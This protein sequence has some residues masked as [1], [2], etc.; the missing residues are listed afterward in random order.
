M[1]VASTQPRHLV[2]NADDL[3]QSPS[4]NAG[5]FDAIEFGIV[6]SASMMVRWDAA[7]DAAEWCRQRPEIGI[8]LHF[9]LGEW[10]FRDGSWHS[11]YEV[12]DA[13]DAVA[14][15][16]ELEWQLDRFEQLMDRAP[17]HLDSHQ[18]V[19]MREPARSAVLSVARSLGVPARGLGDIAYCGQFYGQ[20]GDGDRQPGNISYE[21]LLRLL[22]GIGRGT[23]ELACHPGADHIDDLKSMYLRERVTERDVLCDYRLREQLHARNIELCTFA[24]HR[25]VTV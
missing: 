17:T 14:V 9:D 23:T 12:V 8:G 5:I 11:L 6:T 2:V 1:S 21:S 20:S 3:G 15:R 13:D 4:I 19:H 7:S 24:T 25:G 18:H 16:H 22:D 10:T